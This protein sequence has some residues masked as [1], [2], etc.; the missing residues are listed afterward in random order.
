MMIF[1]LQL[2][3]LFLSNSLYPL[4]TMPVWMRVGAYANPTTYVVSAL[5]NIALSPTPMMGATADLSVGACFVVTTG[6][7]VL[8][9]YIALKAFIRTIQ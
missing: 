3:L 4:T 7:A 6:F 1:L 5:R 9:M 8:G 2:P